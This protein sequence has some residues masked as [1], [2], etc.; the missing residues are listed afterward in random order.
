[1]Q[2]P[3]IQDYLSSKWTEDKYTGA[4]EKCDTYRK[5]FMATYKKERREVIRSDTVSETAESVEVDD[6]QEDTN[7]D[8]RDM[9]TNDTGDDERDE[10]AQAED[11]EPT[12]P[13]TIIRPAKKMGTGFR[14]RATIRAPAPVSTAVPDLAPAP[15]PAPTSTTPSEIAAQA[16]SLASKEKSISS[17]IKLLEKY[18]EIETDEWKRYGLYAIL[19]TLTSA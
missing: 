4:V 11:L 19:L 10:D 6:T 13:A 5:R 17:A 18:I 14:A 7:V 8:V 2:L 3:E 12:H 15:A 1:M 16:I 9:A